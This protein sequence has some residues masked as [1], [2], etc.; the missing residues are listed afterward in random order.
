MLIILSI[1]FLACQIHPSRDYPLKN[2]KPTSQGIRQYVE[3]NS[4]SLI[5]EYQDFVDDTLYNVWIYAVDP[6][7]YDQA[8]S[9]EL[10]WYFPHEIY[11]STEE[12][13][14]AYELADLEPERKIALR[15]CNKFVR[16]VMVHEL[17]HEYVN[18]IAVEMKSRDPRSVHRSYQ[19]D[20]W[21]IRSHETFGSSFIEEGL[22]EYMTEKMGELI[23]PK[24]PFIPATVEELLSKD[25][26]Y[27]VKYKYASAIL[28]PFLD[29]TGFK[30]GVMV[31][32]HNSPPTY[33]EALHPDLY[34]SR[35]VSFEE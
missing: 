25:K 17:T 34:F 16:A 3:E 12:S 23:P 32:L 7:D 1:V 8:D 30:R 18:Q 15:E 11:I 2:G 13:F 26:R 28:Q 35:L 29:S 21:I 6:E 33:E 10:G 24:H 4:G 5:R 27:D 19:T 31:L 9:L 14:V 20:I 22:S